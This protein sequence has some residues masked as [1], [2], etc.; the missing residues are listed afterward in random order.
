MYKLVKLTV[1]ALL[2]SDAQSIQ[3]RSTESLIEQALSQVAVNSTLH[4]HLSNALNT[5]Q[6]K[7]D[8]EVM[9]SHAQTV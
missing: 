3:V 4:A 6:G 9:E 7:S 8:A 2:V 5:V 1:A